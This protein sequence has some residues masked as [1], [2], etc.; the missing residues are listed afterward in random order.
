V[1]EDRN[2]TADRHCLKDKLTLAMLKKV[3]KHKQFNACVSVLCGNFTRLRL[4]YQIVS[5]CVKPFTWAL[6]ALN[7]QRKCKE[8]NNVV[9]SAL[10]LAMVFRLTA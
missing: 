4:S 2:Y 8:H 6:A 3:K 1:S 7:S 5:S 9:F 10:L